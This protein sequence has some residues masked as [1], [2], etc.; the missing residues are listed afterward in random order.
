MNFIWR[1]TQLFKGLTLIILLAISNTSLSNE[2]LAHV[3]GKAEL[4][5]AIEQNKIDINFIVPAETLFGFE[6]RAITKAEMA[7]VTVVTKHVSQPENVLYLHGGDCQVSK[8]NIDT[9]KMLEGSHAPAS[10]SHAEIIINYKFTCGNTD[11]I[12]SLSVMLFK[13]Y[14]RLEEIHAF[15]INTVQQRFSVLN[16]NNKVITLQ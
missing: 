4:T 10:S 3:H 7:K 11:D 8:I 9:S 12:T 14:Q 16:K 13:H 15:W 5:I 1:S 6:H 2:Y